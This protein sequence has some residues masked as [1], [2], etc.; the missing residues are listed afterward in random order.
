MSLST[1]IA[2]PR[3]DPDA[4]TRDWGP[5]SS[6]DDLSAGPVGGRP[7]VGPNLRN[8]EQVKQLIGTAFGRYVPAER[9]FQMVTSAPA[10][11]LRLA[12]S[13]DWIAVRSHAR[14]P[15]EALLDGS[16]GLVVVRGR[17]RLIAPDLARQLPAKDRRR[18]QP[19]AVE[20]RAPVLV[21]APVRALCRAAAR[22][23]GPDLRLAGKRVL[24]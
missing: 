14:T 22:R 21:D 8:S 24:L 20:G 15:A 16:I 23:L 10:C 13:R 6:P 11:V 12:P 2:P 17:I 7:P 5:R 1:Q 3:A 9:L 4:P 18:F 19:L